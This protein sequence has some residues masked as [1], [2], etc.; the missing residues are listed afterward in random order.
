VFPTVLLLV[1]EFSAVARRRGCIAR[2][3][4]LLCRAAMLLR[5]N[6]GRLALISGIQPE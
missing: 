6:I 1:D 3:R 4:L 5:C 2:H